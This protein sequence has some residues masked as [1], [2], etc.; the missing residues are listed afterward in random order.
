M[1][2]L[3]Q[4]PAVA[5]GVF[6]NH[7]VCPNVDDI[8]RAHGASQVA[9][10]EDLL[11]VFGTDKP[12]AAQSGREPSRKSACPAKAAGVWGGR[13]RRGHLQDLLLLL[14]TPSHESLESGDEC[15][16]SADGAHDVVS[17]YRPFLTDRDEG[18]DQAV[19]AERV[20][21]AQRPDTVLQ[22]LVANRTLAVPRLLF[23][24]HWPERSDLLIRKSRSS[25]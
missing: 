23:V 14:S 7:C 11:G 24:H 8:L 18:P 15:N 2:G 4:G 21:T 17:G 13:A 22:T 6:V 12:L 5:T 10:D 25:F 3:A 19:V 1:G 9:D 20:S 16:V